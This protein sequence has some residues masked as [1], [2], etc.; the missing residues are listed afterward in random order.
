MYAS[1][2]T[3]FSQDIKIYRLTS[4]DGE[5]WT[6]NP[7]SA[8][9]SKATG[10][11]DW[12]RKSVETPSVVLFNGKYHLFYTAYPVSLGVV[13]DYKIGHAISLD[14]ISWTRDAN[15]LLA[16]TAARSSKARA[17]NISYKKC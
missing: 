7:T 2:N 16:P 8:V 9:F 14:G 3:N 5:N 11:S 17:S 10:P 15:Y 12:D 1:A 13:T 6:L 4:S